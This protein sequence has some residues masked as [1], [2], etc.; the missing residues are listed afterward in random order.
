MLKGLLGRGKKVL[1]RS[2]GIERGCKKNA[3]LLRDTRHKT[4]LQLQGLLLLLLL[5]LGRGGQGRQGGQR[6][7]IGVARVGRGHLKK[8]AGAR[9]RIAAAPLCPAAI[10]NGG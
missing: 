5:L 6:R 1:A 8:R 3:L 9:L 4:L 10:V 2:K 7:R